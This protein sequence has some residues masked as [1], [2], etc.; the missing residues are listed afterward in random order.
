[1]LKYSLGLRLG[2]DIIESL[3]IQLYFVLLFL[4]LVEF[5]LKP[6][7]LIFFPTEVLLLQVQIT[8][9]GDLCLSVYRETMQN[10]GNIIRSGC[11]GECWS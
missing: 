5:W 3:K 11:V 9:A 8:F 1:M 2:L 6:F 4:Y 7:L 10:F